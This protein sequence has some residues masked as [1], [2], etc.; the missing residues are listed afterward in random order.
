MTIQEALDQELIYI[1]QGFGDEL[2]IYWI[3]EAATH[4]R[5][6]GFETPIISD[7]VTDLHFSNGKLI[8]V[9]L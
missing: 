7:K 8:S 6:M 3:V 5:V 2:Y 1:Q 4:E 9:F